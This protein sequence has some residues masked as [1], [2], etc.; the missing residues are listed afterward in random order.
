M[1]EIEYTV[2]RAKIKNIYIQIKNGKVIVKAPKQVKEEYLKELVE[3][4]SK[5]I[6]KKLEDGRKETKENNKP[7]TEKQIEYLKQTI[8]TSIEKYTKNIGQRPRKITIKNIK[9]AWGSCSAKKNITININLAR[10]K[11]EIIEYVVLHE[12]CHLREMN[13]SKKFWDLVEK[14]MPKYKEYRKQLK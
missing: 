4:K 12:L 7:I 10:K 8:E 13:H 9:Y 6:N 11:K 14:N 2:V 1:E 3:K 5:W